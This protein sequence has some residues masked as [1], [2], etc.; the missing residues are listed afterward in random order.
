MF[1]AIR[2]FAAAGPIAQGEI[3]PLSDVRGAKDFRL[4][5]AETILMKLYHE[6]APAE[7]TA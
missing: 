2:T 7:V 4:L 5:L 6:L 3:A 1:A